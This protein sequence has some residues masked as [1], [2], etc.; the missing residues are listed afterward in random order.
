[1]RKVG[2]RVRYVSRVHGPGTGVIV[3]VTTWRHKVYYWVD[4]YWDSGDRFGTKSR[5]G[6]DDLDWQEGE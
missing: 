3:R 4:W 6:R 5:A 1:M 2:D